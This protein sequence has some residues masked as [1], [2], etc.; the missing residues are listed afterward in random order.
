MKKK[1]VELTIIIPIYNAEKY[2]ERSCRS[3]ME[4]TKKDIDFIFVNDC[5]KDN[6]LKRLKEI[7]S[8][9]PERISH[10]SIINN[11]KNLGPSESRKIAINRSTS[12]YVGFCDADDWVEPDMY[13]KMCQATKGNQMDVVVCNYLMERR[14]ETK[15]FK[16]IPC[17]NSQKCLERLDDP[18]RFSYAM[19]NQIIRLALVKE[20]IEQI[21]S[22]KFREDTYLMMR[23]YY[24]ATS[25]S[26]IPKAFY[27]Y[28]VENPDSLIHHRN[29]SVKGWNEQKDNFDRIVRLLYA[30]NGYNR[31]HQAVNNFKFMLKMEYK[32]VFSNL[33]DY[34]Y[35]YREAH[36]DAITW[37]N[38]STDS[39]KNKIIMYI[40]YN[41]CYP[42]F[43]LYNYICSN[44]KQLDGSKG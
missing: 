14:K 10:V 33:K 2:I 13:E 23:V 11:E 44:K 42:I 4:Q 30:D 20:E 24:R 6:T 25:I 29:I 37:Y 26:F 21:I 17:E 18:H 9:Y 40:V 8:D 38:K 22:T 36:K 5:S 39:I 19:W 7:L 35:A 28:W 32:D 16:L 27:H 41:T 12:E 31:Y 3:L 43:Y 15:E 34:Y 1:M